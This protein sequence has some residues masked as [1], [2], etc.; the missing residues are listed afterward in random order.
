MSTTDKTLA[1]KWGE[2]AI[3]V[4][5]INYDPDHIDRYVS[6]HHADG[7]NVSAITVHP[8]AALAYEK[9][10]RSGY[11]VWAGI[12]ALFKCTTLTNY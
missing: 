9:R 5:G 2:L 6:Q 7:R 1:T 8:D 3:S 12:K 4:N 10:E 11:S